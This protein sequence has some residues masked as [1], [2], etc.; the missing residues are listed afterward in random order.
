MKR[1]PPPYA[2]TEAETIH[3][4]LDHQRASVL[5]K[6]EGLDHRALNQRCDASSLTLAGLLKHLALVEDSWFDWRFAGNDEREPWASAPWD[7]DSDWEFTTAPAHQPDELIASYQ[8]ACRRSRAVTAEIPL[9]TLSA[10]PDRDGGHWSLR[11]ILLHMI[12]ETARHA[13]HADFIRESID[14]Q[15]GA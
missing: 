7:E 5:I 2:A 15:T 12:E 11:W 6:A 4:F 8:D 10:R 14:G 9:D 3:A 13:G 1:P